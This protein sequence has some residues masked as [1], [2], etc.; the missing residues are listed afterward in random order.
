MH[1]SKQLIDSKVDIRNNL[2]KM[3]ARIH[4]SYQKSLGLAVLDSEEEEKT[5]KP[6]KINAIKVELINDDD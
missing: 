2:E 4:K 1:G 5:I 3:N 6:R